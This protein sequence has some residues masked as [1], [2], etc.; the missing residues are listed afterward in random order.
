[1]ACDSRG[2]RSRHDDRAQSHLGY[3]C[4]STLTGNRRNTA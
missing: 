4:G 1:M 3:I 2:G